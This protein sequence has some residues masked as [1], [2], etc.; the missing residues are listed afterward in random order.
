MGH[1]ASSACFGVHGYFVM[2]AKTEKTPVYN[3]IAQNR[4][5][6]FMVILE[7]YGRSLCLCVAFID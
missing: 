4:N 1:R 2:I 7:C 5:G 6:L 3:Y